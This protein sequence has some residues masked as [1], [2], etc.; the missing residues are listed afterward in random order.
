[1]PES[2]DSDGPREKSAKVSFSSE[3]SP[4]LVVETTSRSAHK[5][6]MDEKWK[7]YARAEAANYT[8]MYRKE[9]ESN[10]ESKTTVVRR[11]HFVSSVWRTW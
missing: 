4:M 1:M 10:M 5:E 11:G 3:Q 2:L 6:N 9:I 7:Y 8:F